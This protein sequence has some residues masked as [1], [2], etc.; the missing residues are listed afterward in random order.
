[1]T[2]TCT[3]Q[4]GTARLPAKTKPDIDVDLTPQELEEIA[5]YTIQKINNYPKSLGKTVDNYFDL[6]YPDEIKSYLMMRAI[7]EKSFSGINVIT[8]FG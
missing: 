6:L 4:Q 3:V 7:N 2:A 1:M 8:S 5:L